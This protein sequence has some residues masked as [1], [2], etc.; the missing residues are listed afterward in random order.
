[1]VSQRKCIVADLLKAER[2]GGYLIRLSGNVLKKLDL[3]FRCS[4]ENVSVIDEDHV[5]P[6]EFFPY[7]GYSGRHLEHAVRLFVVC[8]DIG[9][10]AFSVHVGGGH[11]YDVGVSR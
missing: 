8:E 1:M 9:I 5:V 2:H 11:Y 6:A 10:P 4:L 3:G 7:L